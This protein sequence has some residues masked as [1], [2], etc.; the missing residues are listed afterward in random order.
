MEIFPDM[1]GKHP[2]TP[3]AGEPRQAAPPPDTDRDDHDD[4][5]HQ[6]GH[7]AA[8]IALV[9]V[10]LAIACA[11]PATTSNTEITSALAR[12][13]PTRASASASVLKPRTFY[14]APWGRDRDKGTN[15]VYPWRTVGR[16]NRA[17]LRAGDRVLFR[18]GETF[19]DDAL[20]PGHGVSVSGA[21]GR[22]VRFG[23]YG[24]G[25]AIL[26]Y[27]IWLGRN[28]RYPRGPSHLAFS[29]LALGPHNGFQGTGDNISLTDLK[30][31]NLVHRSA[32][33]ETG[34]E[35]EGSH[36]MIAH[37]VIDRT[38][39][40]G[41]LLGFDSSAPGVAAGGFDYTVYDNTIDHT[42]LDPRITVGTH[43]IYLKV[44]DATVL[45]NRI[46]NFRN[47][48]VSARYRNARIVDN[49]I[50]HGSIGIAWF[51]YDTKAGM[52]AFIGNTIGDTHSAAIYVCGSADSCRQPLEAFA[53]RRNRLRAVHGARMNLEPSSGDYTVWNNN[54]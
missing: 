22:P 31:T 48:G 52:S 36:W 24:G 27:G 35:T 32:T 33:N 15:S 18:G 38:G 5:D 1:W 7:L 25:R 2:S 42:G 3:A 45:H 34:I 10:A 8:R 28:D 53:I 23:A 43:G 39:D 16:V 44:A 9:V 50:E 46:L 14:V 41:M 30:I 17:N 6:H 19:A 47:D 21:P 54:R 20:M 26:P 29:G 11:L 40:S 4:H 13:I 49:D 37:N 12:T 51:Q